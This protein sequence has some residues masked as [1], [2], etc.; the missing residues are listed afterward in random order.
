LVLKQKK[1]GILIFSLFLDHNNKITL[2]MKTP[3]SLLIFAV[4]LLVALFPTTWSIST[5]R[6]IRMFNDAGVKVEIYWINPTTR[7]TVLMSAPFIYDGAQ[8]PLNSFV[9][10]EFEVREVANAKTGDCSSGDQTCHSNTFVVTDHDNQG[11]YL[12]CCSVF[13]ACTTYRCYTLEYAQC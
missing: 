1:T 6:A 11:A 13:T 4:G 9:G 3:S 2:T 10:H 12:R 7:E 8:F 5:E